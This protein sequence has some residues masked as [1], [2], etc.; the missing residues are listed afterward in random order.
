MLL[1]AQ[2]LF[3]SQK[4]APATDGV[5]SSKAKGMQGPGARGEAA[6]T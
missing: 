6:Q 5:L 3:L 2:R 1:V 4:Q